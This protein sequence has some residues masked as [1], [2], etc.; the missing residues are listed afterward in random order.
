MQ[1]SQRLQSIIDLSRRAGAE[2]MRYYDAQYSVKDKANHTQVTDADMAADGMIRK[3]LLESFPYPVLSEE[4]ADDPARL[5]ADTLWIVDPLDGTRDFINHTGEFCVMIGLLE[6][7]RPALGVVYVPVE[8]TIYYAERGQGA[9]RAVKNS[10]PEPIH[11]SAHAAISDMTVI[12]GRAQEQ[13]LTYRLAMDLEAKTVERVNS[14]GVKAAR[15]AEGRADIYLNATR[16]AS[17]WDTCAADII[18]T[19]AGGKFSD[20]YGHP[21]RYNLP[22]VVHYHGLLGSNGILHDNIVARVAPL[23]PKHEIDLPN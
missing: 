3:F 5:A 13:E 12:V 23:L 20:L 2:I 9:F 4:T 19:E 14:V 16:H 11:V 17:E 22:D 1:P 7:G 6:Q 15:L 21:L 18:I 8:N 10:A